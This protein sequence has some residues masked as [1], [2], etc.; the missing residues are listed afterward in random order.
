MI[1]DTT[2]AIDLMNK[3]NEALLKYRDLLLVGEPIKISSI[4]VFELHSGPPIANKPEGERRMVEQVIKGQIILDFT[5]QAA[6]KAGELYGSSVK[7]GKTL[8]IMDCMIASVAL[9]NNEKILTR[10]IKDFERIP[11]VQIETY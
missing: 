4:S 6:E 5:R 8:S 3:N 11:Q 9:V 1:L 7:S 10:N 2:F